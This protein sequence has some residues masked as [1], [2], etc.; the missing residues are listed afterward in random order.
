MEKYTH[1]LNF[2]EK[3]E[4]LISYVYKSLG[5]DRFMF[6]PGANVQ[7]KFVFNENVFISDWI[8]HSSGCG[9]QRMYNWILTVWSAKDFLLEHDL[10]DNNITKDELYKNFQE[11]N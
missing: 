6:G 1:K 8:H 11:I 5:N 4:V 10:I 9:N 2:D 7:M 3:G